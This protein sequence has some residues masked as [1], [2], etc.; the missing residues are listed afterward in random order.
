[1]KE[2]ELIRNQI[3]KKMA[4]L[5]SSSSSYHNIPTFTGQRKTAERL[6]S[7]EFYKNAKRIFIPPDAAQFEARLSVLRDGKVLVMASP[8]LRDGFYEVH[9]G[10]LEHLWP[11]SIKSSGIR[12]WGKKLKTTKGDI[13][14]INL[15]VTGAVAVSPNG[16][17]V[18]KGT[19]YFDW[20][21]AILR[22]IGCIDEE[23]PIVAL[24]HD[25]QVCEKLPFQEKDVSVN[26]IITP[27]RTLAAEACRIRP[28]GIDWDQMD[29]R[30]LA[31]MRPLRELARLRR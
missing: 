13:G 20:E 8:R 18:G 12:K 1:M 30:T 27:T 28:S 25:L 17:R 16:E 14:K 6:R 29:R 3:W 19:G 9:P 31:S 4:A 7:I 21:Y 24:V 10:R 15:M 22:E 5:D 2:K 26:L 23:T 11:R